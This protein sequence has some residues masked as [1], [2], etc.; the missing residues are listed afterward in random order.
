M[1]TADNM[2]IK[3]TA[4]KILAE[5]KLFSESELQA[6]LDSASESALIDVTK[7]KPAFGSDFVRWVN[8]ECFAGDR[9]NRFLDFWKNY[10]ASYDKQCSDNPHYQ[11][12]KVNSSL[13]DVPLEKFYFNS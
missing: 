13:A 1:D 12:F 7:R 6:I 3:Q 10:F 5:E 8:E 4:C 11:R 9:G 2:E